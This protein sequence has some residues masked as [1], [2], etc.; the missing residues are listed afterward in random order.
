MPAKPEPPPVP[1]G[2][3]GIA[4]SD[5]VSAGQVR[6]VTAVDRYLVVYRGEAGDAHV[7]DAHCPHLGAHLGGGRVIGD[8]LKCPYHGWQY[9][10]EGRCVDIPYNG[11]GHIPSRACVRSY[12]VAEK[13]GFVHFWFH[14]ADKPPAYEI[15]DLAEPGDPDWTD[16]YVWQTELV[17]SL[18][19]MAENNVDYAHLRYV[20][21]RPVVPG[22]VS[23]FS[24]DGP[25]SRVVE[26]LPGGDATFTRDSWGPGI[27]Y[28]QIPG[29]MAIHAATTPIDRE[30]CRLRWHFYFP[31]AWEAAAEELIEAVTGEH[32]IQADVPIW[33]DKIY[34]DRP[35][36]V[37]GDGPIAE[38]RR[39]YAQF[40]EGS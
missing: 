29:L 21:K 10:P 39:W 26:T 8:H 37:K 34:V 13:D 18:Q 22:D 38:F 1:N 17:A 31:R 35:V 19:E 15:P 24:T 25:F 4:G 27:T 5:E 2:W 28:M 20:H 12:P 3:Y 6:S 11:D 33:R 32:G 14:A 16:P 23:E 36:L 9:G 40:Y 7:L 30:H